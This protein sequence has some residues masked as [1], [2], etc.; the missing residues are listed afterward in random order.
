MASQAAGNRSTLIV[1][2][3]DTHIVANARL[4]LNQ[5]DTSSFLRAAVETVRTLTVRP[6]AVLI[7]GDLYN[8]Q[9]FLD[10]RSY[11]NVLRWAEEIGARPAVQRGKRVNKT[12]GPE[13]QQLAERHDASD[14][15]RPAAT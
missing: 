8:A 9:E 1:Q 14:F 6:D 10:V 4:C 13:D 15:D 5:I 12:W 11:Q 2:L 3:T 7:T